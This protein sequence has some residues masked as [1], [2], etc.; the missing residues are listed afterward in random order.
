M[1]LI[2]V[3]YITERQIFTFDFIFKRNGNAYE[4]TN[5]LERFLSFKGDKFNYS[6]RDIEQIL[7]F[8]PANLLFD[9]DI[10]VDIEEN[11]SSFKWNSSEI[12]AFYKIPDPFASVFYLLADYTNYLPKKRDE[13]NRAIANYSLSASFNWLEKCKADEWTVLLLEYLIRKKFT[14]SLPDTK[15]SLLL[16]FDIDNTFA[17]KLKDGF[18]GKLSLLKDYLKV[19]RKRIAERRAVNRNELKDPYDTFDYI[20]DL[21]KNSLPVKLFYLVGDFTKF[22]RN[23]SFKDLRHQRHINQLSKELEIGLHPSYKS[24]ANLSQ[25]KEEKK[26]LEETIKSGVQFSRQHFLK[27]NIPHTYRDLIQLGFKDDYT[28]GYADAVGFRLGTSRSIPFY[29]LLRNEITSLMLHPFAYMDGTLNQYLGLSI[30]DAK[31]KVK[32]LYDEVDKYGGEFISIWHNET[33]GDNGIWK[34]WRAVLDETIDYHIL[35]NEKA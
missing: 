31:T 3:E 33:I 19:D 2:F 16:T 13:H 30:N 23:I 1:I 8:P 20:K 26:R 4:L 25:L 11:I 24:N 35:K 10:K 34:G 27:L 14:V 9:E 18:R 17:Y 12:L 29:D 22:D 5:D 7:Q 15:T 32:A 21:T 28:S 6:D